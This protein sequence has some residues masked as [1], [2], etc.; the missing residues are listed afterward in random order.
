MNMKEVQEKIISAIK[1]GDIDLWNPIKVSISE[2]LGVKTLKLLKELRDSHGYD[3]VS[4]VDE[5][6]DAWECHVNA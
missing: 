6:C 1:S 4:I 5:L 3:D 2:E